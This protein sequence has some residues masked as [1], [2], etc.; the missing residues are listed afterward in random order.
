M[1]AARV[2]GSGAMVTRRAF[3]AAAGGAVAAAAVGVAVEQP[4]VRRWAVG[5]VDPEP[6][7][8]APSSAPGPLTSGVLESRARGREV[9]WRVAYP[10][11]HREGDVLPVALVLHGRGGNQDSAFSDLALDG[12]LA[13][14]VAP[15]ARPF[16][17]ASVD[18]GDHGY[19][20]ARRDG[21][22]PQTMLTDEFVPLLSRHGLVT[23][24]VAVLGWSMGGYGALLL[25]ET[26]GP[27]RIAAVA[28]DSP[29][30]WLR[31]ADSA[32]GAFDGAADFAA[33]DVFARRSRL[34]GIPVRIACGD[35]DPFCPAVREFVTGVPDLAGT[36]FSTGEHTNTYWR[37]TAPAQL[38]FLASALSGVR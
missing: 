4:G 10:P 18:G 29:A 26:A 11:G 27:S 38:R 1:M 12:Y 17:L 36:D 3:L 22:D 34:A 33:H 2:P 13:D 30:L 20:H 5:L 14:V 24:R 31:A 9:A 6:R 19:W 35:R 23:S 32:S 21:D 8:P 28:A 7:A 15:G 25:A 37:R 16:A